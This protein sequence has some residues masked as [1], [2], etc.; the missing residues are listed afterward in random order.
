MCKDVLSTGF[1]GQA[2]LINIRGSVV[3]ETTES[4]SLWG[5]C[6]FLQ[7]LQ[8]AYTHTQRD[9][10]TKTNKNK[11]NTETH[12]H[13]HTHNHTHT[14]THTHT[15]PHTHTHTHWTQVT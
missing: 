8:S 12:T 2:A 1:S 9:T 7:F 15:H 11:Q 6:H 5:L 14:H 13:T 4:S 3:F 10:H